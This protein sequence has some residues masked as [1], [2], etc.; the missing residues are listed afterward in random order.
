MA[1]SWAKSIKRGQSIFKRR[2]AW[3]EKHGD[4]QNKKNVERR[5]K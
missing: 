2:R 1:F 3:F 5:I 4:S